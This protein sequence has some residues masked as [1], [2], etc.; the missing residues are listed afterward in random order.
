[1]RC[2]YCRV[3]V[4]CTAHAPRF[5]RS[6]R[7][8]LNVAKEIVEKERGGIWTQSAVGREAVFT[9]EPPLMTLDAG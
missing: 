2:L 6:M 5:M 1:M 8:D 3:T 4:I 9:V 7:I